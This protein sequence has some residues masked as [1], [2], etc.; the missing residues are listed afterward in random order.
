MASGVRFIGYVTVQPSTGDAG[1]ADCVQ[2]TLTPGR[3]AAELPPVS[4]L[5]VSGSEHPER[6]PSQPDAPS[7]A[8]LPIAL[9]ADRWM[10]RQTRSREHTRRALRADSAYVSTTDTIRQERTWAQA[11]LKAVGRAHRYGA[12]QF[13]ITMAT[14]Q[15]L[16][17]TEGC[18]R[19][20]AP[21]S[22]MAISHLSRAYMQAMLAAVDS[23]ANEIVTAL[24]Q[25]CSPGVCGAQQRQRIDR[26][27]DEYL[28]RVR[29]LLHEKENCY[30][31]ERPEPVGA[32]TAT[33]IR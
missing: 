2:G 28:R 8:V 10:A 14:A 16:V 30:G 1:H 12:A 22:A 32:G 6:H 21:A 11:G 7:A 18:D 4:V 23:A 19:Q 5:V 31:E 24:T 17:R 29:M 33:P 20:D 13:A 15:T 9:S 3:A 25:Q 27:S 26:L